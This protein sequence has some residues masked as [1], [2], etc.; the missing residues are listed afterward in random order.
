MDAVLISSAW[1]GWT[2]G[3][4][5]QA[6]AESGT[7]KAGQTKGRAYR[8]ADDPNRATIALN[9]LWLLTCWNLPKIP[10]PSLQMVL[11]FGPRLRL[12][13]PY[14]RACNALAC[15]LR[16]AE[17]Y[18]CCFVTLFYFT[19]LLSVL[20]QDCQTIRSWQIRQSEMANLVP[21]WTQRGDNWYRHLVNSTKHNVV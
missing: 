13:L 18:N 10:Y 14:F 17:S 3:R 11:L 19:Y 12:R 6:Q 15:I 16:L 9:W 2:D 20:E 4:A 8:Q 1:H 5:R 21:A 7:S